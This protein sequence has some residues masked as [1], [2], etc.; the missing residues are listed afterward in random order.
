LIAFLN[1]AYTDLFGSSLYTLADCIPS[2]LFSCFLDLL[3]R[4]APTQ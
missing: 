1:V 4:N 2:L 3:S